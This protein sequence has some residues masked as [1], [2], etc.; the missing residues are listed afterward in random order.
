MEQRR[1]FIMIKVT[2]G[3]KRVFIMIKV[4]NWGKERVFIMIKVTNGAKKSFHN[5]KGN[6][7]GKESLDNDFVQTADFCSRRVHLALLALLGGFVT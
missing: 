2:N 7:Q 5:D 4:T 6:Q 1:V 3:E